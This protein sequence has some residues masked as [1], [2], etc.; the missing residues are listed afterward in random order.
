MRRRPAR[1]ALRPALVTLALALAALAGLIVLKRD[2]RFAV[3]RVVL[4]GVPEAR[5]A[6]AEEVTD[7][8][9][10]RPLFFVNL[11]GAV[12]ELSRRPWVAR[13][14]A[15]RVVPD[16]LVV[17][18]D[19]RPPFALA[20]HGAELWTVDRS[21][22]WLGPYAGRTASPE[23]DFPLLDGPGDAESLRRG[24][25]FLLA[26]KAEDPDL[27]ARVSEVSVGPAGALVTD[28]GVRARLLLLADPAAAPRAA[29]AWRAW[30]AL[31]PELT[32]RGLPGDA[33]DLRFE[34]RI[35]VKAPPDVLGR[36]NT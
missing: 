5:R 18:V 28:R 8:L 14:A 20:R 9:L 13:A 26:L 34:G 29:A 21:G 27:F 2:A 3:R 25:A 22:V 10:G 33:A 1:H 19:V 23:D 4:E 15:R 24:T 6:E 11:D 31:L 30:L 7:A 32:R 35:F 12:S 36:G 17:R 16:T